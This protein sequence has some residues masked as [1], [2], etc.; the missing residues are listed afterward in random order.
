[1]I[2][3]VR[4]INS[5]RGVLAVQT[6]EGYSLCELLGGNKPSIGDRVECDLYPLGSAIIINHSTGEAVQVYFQD[7]GVTKERAMDFVGP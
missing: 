5:D 3:I 6:D 4:E 1:M 7:H 2:G